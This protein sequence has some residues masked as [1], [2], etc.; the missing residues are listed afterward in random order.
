MLRRL[1]MLCG[2]TLLSS[3]AYAQK[4]NPYV[5]VQ[6]ETPAANTVL[7]APAS[8]V[9]SASAGTI[10]DGVNVSSITLY[11]GGAAIAQVGYKESISFVVNGLQPGTYNFSAR[12]TSDHGGSATTPTR[13]VSV[14]AAGNKPPSINL[15][16][17]IGGPFF[18][19]AIV[20]LAANASDSDGN[21]VQVD[22]FADGNAIGSSTISPYNMSWTEAPAG[23]HSITAR[24]TDNNGKQTTSAPLTVTVEQSVITGNID[25]VAATQG[26][27]YSIGGWACSTGRNTP[28]DVH[29]YLGGPAGSG[30]FFTAVT[31]NQS[32]DAAIASACRAQ[33]SAYRFSIPLDAAARQRYANQAIYIHGISP[34]G[35]GNNLLANSGT[36]KVPAPASVARRYVYDEYERLCKTIEPETGATVVDYDTAG[37]IGW[38]AGG[39]SLPDLHNCNRE[40]ALASGRVVLRNYDVRN[41]LSWLSFP[42]K[43][44]DQR[45]KYTPD[46]LPARIETNTTDGGGKVVVNTY[47]YNKRRLLTGER[48]D[49]WTSLMVGYAYD[50]NGALARLLYPSR[51]LVDY[52]PNALGQPTQ[53]GS[54]AYGI[55][56]HPNGAVAQFTYGNG[57]VHSMSMNVRQLPA[58]VSDSGVQQYQYSYDPNDNVTAILDQTQGDTYSR[59]LEYDARNRLKVAASPSFGGAGAHR[60]SYDGQDNLRT[61]A[62]G[63]TSYDYYYDSAN[64]LT[65]LTETTTGASVVG[66]GYDAQGNLTNKNG[67]AYSFTLGNQLRSV[68]GRQWYAYDGYGRRVIACGSGP[69]TYQLYSQAGALLHTRDASKSIDTDYLYLAGSVVATRARPAAG[70]TETVTYQHTD[71]LGSPVATTNAAGQVVERTQYAPYGAAIGKT[72]DGIGYTGHAMDGDTGLIYMQ[73]R[74]YDP[75]IPRFLSVDPVTPYEKP[76]TNFNRYVYALNNPYRFTDPDGRD[77]VGEM[78]DAKAMEAAGRGEGF[79]TYGWAFAA[80][81]WNYL[82]AEGVSQVADKG[83]DAG[84]GNGAMAVL[85]IATLGKGGTVLKAGE[86]IA[87][88]A[89]K[90]SIKGMTGH[91]VDQA[92]NRGVK[93]AQIVDA[94]KDPLKVA[95]AKV[96]ALGRQSQKI[97]G[98]KATVVVNPETG[99]IV[100]VY[101]T[102]SR[103]AERLLEQKK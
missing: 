48:T 58:V 94:I 46:G 52:A 59:T 62:T 10:D 41:R 100:T 91:A 2:W 54:F 73:Q 89:A 5:W 69:C 14:V 88:G 39:L 53:V 16:D 1:L 84:K 55:R 19:P 8:V 36:F 79:A 45:W 99:K 50:A 63:T 87:E 49:G 67:Q 83:M 61:H 80:T 85:E 18:A 32:S 6:L 20:G 51:L 76:I 75:A 97:V 38:T 72:V 35:G 60:Y 101:P 96:D 4:V 70:G 21:V 37:N 11:Q 64:R 31:A 43:N 3:V 102:S 15:Y 74:Y 29:V 47:G 77:S 9:V 92:I 82:G 93:P 34:V 56:Y 78:I 17:A 42:D 40:E 57:V 33:G 25:G 86:K 13:A 98:E 81:A 68:V 71:A 7:T 23:D 22:Y 90:I 12:A 44:G 65:N 30:T 27:P 66:M 95:E 24:A 103:T 28:V 26:G